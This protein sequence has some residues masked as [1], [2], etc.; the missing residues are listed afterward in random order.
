MWKTCLYDPVPDPYELTNLIGM[1]SHQEVA[2]VLK[3]RLLDRMVQA[4]ES[5][6]VIESVELKPSSHRMADFKES[7]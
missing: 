6:P 2:E 3:R 4:G 5:K 1:Q 7:L